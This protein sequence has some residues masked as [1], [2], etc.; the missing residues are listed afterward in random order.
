VFGPSRLL[1]GSDWPLCLVAAPYDRVLAAA[2]ETLGG[3]GDAETDAVFGGTAT[4]IY[5]LG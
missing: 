5:R 4:E 1:F 2:R 3:L